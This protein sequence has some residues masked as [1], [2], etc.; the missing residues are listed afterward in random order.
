M[1]LALAM[2][3]TLAILASNFLAL[4]SFIEILGSRQTASNTSLSTLALSL[5][6]TD[7]KEARKG[8]RTCN[9]PVG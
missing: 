7:S 4:A 2:P 5:S 1:Y 9:I 6:L 8:L 3:L